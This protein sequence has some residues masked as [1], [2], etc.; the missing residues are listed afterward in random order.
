MDIQYTRPETRY[1]VPAADKVLINRHYTLGYSFYFRQAKWALEII[2]EK[3]EDVEVERHD[4]FRSDF[5]I[6]P[7]FRADLK[8][9]YKS[10]FD[11]GHLVASANQ[12][13]KKIQ[14]SETFLL[15][16]MAPQHPGFN[17]VIWRQLEK[18]IRELN[19]RED[20]YETYVITGP[21]FYFDQ[22]VTCIG[23]DDDNGVSLPVPHAFFK[24]IL[25]EDKMGKF[26]LW[27]FLVPNKE[28]DDE[29][30]DFLVTTHFVEKVAGI[31]LWENLHGEKIEKKKNKKGKLWKAD[32]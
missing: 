3:D 15:S 31:E 13:D 24:S 27:S 19:G 4:N 32:D 17:R 12:I 10:G 25:A 30:K 9:Y 14:N 22:M 6:P 21:I 26:H 2:D 16:N 7:Y 1:G 8:D 5:R 20:I 29:L 18:S 11:R 23:E 28:A